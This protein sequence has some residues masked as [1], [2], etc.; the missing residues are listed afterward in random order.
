[1]DGRTDR[2]S[3]LKMLRMVPSS[4]NKSGGNTIFCMF[5]AFLILSP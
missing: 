4:R 3:D 5:I 1:M 2:L